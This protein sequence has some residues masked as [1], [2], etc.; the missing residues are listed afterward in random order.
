[1]PL[2]NTIE[3]IVFD[4]DGTIID[5]IGPIRRPHTAPQFNSAYAQRYGDNTTIYPGMHSPGDSWTLIGSTTITPKGVTIRLA[6]TATTGTCTVGAG[7]IGMILCV[8]T[9]EYVVCGAGVAVA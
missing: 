4:G 5:L 2:V 6:G 7:G 9:N 1:M 3:E 8:G